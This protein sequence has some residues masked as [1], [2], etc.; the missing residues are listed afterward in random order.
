MRNKVLKKLIAPLQKVLL[1]KK[2]C[3]ACTR[4]LR[5]GKFLSSTEAEDIIVCECG[6]IFIHE[7]EL[8]IFRRALPEDLKQLG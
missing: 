4:N 7:K 1:Q 3:P 6:R 8:D 2:Y 5:Q